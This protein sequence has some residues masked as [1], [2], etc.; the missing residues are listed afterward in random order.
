M[1]HSIT[2]TFLSFLLRKSTHDEW[3]WESSRQRNQADTPFVVFTG[4][5]W[6]TKSLPPQNL[7]TP[8][9]TQHLTSFFPTR[10]PPI[11]TYSHLCGLYSS[12]NTSPTSSLTHQTFSF[13]SSRPSNFNYSPNFLISPFISHF[14]FFI[15]SYPISPFL[16]N[17]NF[18]LKFTPFL[19]PSP[20]LPSPLCDS[21]YLQSPFI[22]YFFK[23][24][25]PHY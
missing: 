23:F 6:D 17:K 19:S 25:T 18:F 7:L 21:I 11:F 12:P 22:S 10:M 2:T 1:T 20:N 13:Y 3:P 4:T 15:S 9:T 24:T 8:S 5:T 16:L 14:P